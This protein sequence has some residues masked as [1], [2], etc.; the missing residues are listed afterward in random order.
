MCSHQIQFALLV[1][2]SICY[3]H[4]L[5]SH[6]TGLWDAHCTVIFLT[7]AKMAVFDLKL[8]LCVIRNVFPC[9]KE[10]LSLCRG[11]DKIIQTPSIHWN[12][13]SMG[14]TIRLCGHCT[15]CCKNQYQTK[16]FLLCL[17]LWSI[18]LQPL[19]AV[20]LLTPSGNSTGENRRTRKQYYQ[21]GGQIGPQIAFS[22]NLKSTVQSWDMQAFRQIDTSFSEHPL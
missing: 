12:T 10:H 11:K 18:S 8:W 14:T 17:R 7:W 13:L 9:G 3:R 6:V 16:G 15:N 22:C 21:K 1:R 2:N 19:A 4:W 20:L 5:S